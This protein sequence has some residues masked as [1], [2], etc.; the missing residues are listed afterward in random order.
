M[1]NT[2]E[3]DLVSTNVVIQANNCAGVVLCHDCSLIAGLRRTNSAFDLLGIVT[4]NSF[5]KFC[6]MIVLFY[7]LKYCI[8]RNAQ[9]DMIQ[10]D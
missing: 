3:L 5:K 7:A 4:S 8:Y 2:K 10:F 1:C 9:Y 6:F